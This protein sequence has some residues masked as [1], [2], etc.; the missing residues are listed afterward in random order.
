MIVTV[1]SI[2]IMRPGL[3]NI[4]NEP[5][6]IS[7]V[8]TVL[9]QVGPVMTDRLVNMSSITWLSRRAGNPC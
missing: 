4:V 5:A 1:V 8:L 3:I 2:V 9:A 6:F 7:S